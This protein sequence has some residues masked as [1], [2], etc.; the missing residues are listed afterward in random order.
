MLVYWKELPRSG[1]LSH[2]T[3]FLRR[4]RRNVLNLVLYFFL[5]ELNDDL[6]IGSCKFSSDDLSLVA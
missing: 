5:Y 1:V 3:R 2:P 4:K 6:A